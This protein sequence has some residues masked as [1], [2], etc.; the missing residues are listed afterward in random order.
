M[1][2]HFPRRLDSLTAIT[3]FLSDLTE[4]LE[5]EPAVS[6]SVNMAVEEL[7]TNMVKYNGHGE[8][9]ILVAVDRAPG[10]VEIRL[11][12][13]DSEPFDITRIREVDV[14]APLEDRSPGGLG[15]HLVRKLMDEITYEYKDRRTSIRLFKKHD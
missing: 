12:D 1:Q 13:F 8:Q 10:G 9:D 11:V 5:L 6:F 3:T 7:F 14:T 4:K 2:Q 15:I